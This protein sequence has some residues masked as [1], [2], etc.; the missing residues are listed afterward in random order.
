MFIKIRNICLL[1][2]IFFPIILLPIFAQDDAGLNEDAEGKTV[3]K[4]VAGLK[5]EVP[6]DRPIEE[7]NNIVSPIPLDEYVAL[8]F[9]KLES[10][11]QK[12]EESISQ[13]QNQ[14]NI[15]QGQLNSP[16]AKESPSLKP[17]SIDR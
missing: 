7:K 9:S 16:K 15:I 2:V 4:T 17:E 11:L 12:I 3:V 5:F 14:L 6:K 13:I 10:R 8:K 1:V